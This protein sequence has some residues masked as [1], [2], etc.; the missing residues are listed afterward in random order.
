[1]GGAAQDSFARLRSRLEEKSANPKARPVTYVAFGDSVTQ[2]AMERDTLEHEHVFH[3][4][5]R[6][7]VARTYPLAV[8]NAINCGAGGETAIESALRWERD[9]FMYQPDFVTIGFGLND[10]FMEDAGL[11][12]Y[13]SSIRELVRILRLRTQADVL[14][15]AP[16]V[17]IRKENACVH[18]EERSLIPRFVKLH[19]EGHLQRYRDAM[20]RLA[21][22][23]HIP[24]LDLAG[25]WRQVEQDGGDIHKR[26]ANGINHP[27][28]AFHRMMA[29]AIY[30]AVFGESV[31]AK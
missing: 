9:I 3:H 24:C 12:L 22:Q 15:L 23:D 29:E 30:T 7:L 27:D 31:K 28:R 8:L 16:G 26:L 2:G 10:A 5:F 21:Q 19:E 20:L 11:P 1:M 4:I 13:V 18:P 14:L 17:M 25:L 6:R